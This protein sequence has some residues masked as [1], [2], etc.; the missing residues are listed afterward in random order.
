MTVL[1]FFA[2]NPTA[3]L[4]PSF[5]G[6]ERLVKAHVGSADETCRTSDL[7]A[8][9][10]ELSDETREQLITVYARLME[11][12][13]DKAHGNLRA[14]WLIEAQGWKERMQALIA[15]RS[16]AAGAGC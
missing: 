12:C 8:N 14:F 9:T 11:E 3:E 10:G 4:P 2:R 1:S 6:A 7:Y 16:Q 15:Q 5:H 13:V